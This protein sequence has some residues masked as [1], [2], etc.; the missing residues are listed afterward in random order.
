MAVSAST[1]AQ[2][3]AWTSARS[4][5]APSTFRSC[6][7]SRLQRFPPQRPD[8]KIGPSTARGFVAP[9]SRSWS[10][11]RFRSPVGLAAFRHLVRR[12]FSRSSPV[13]RTLRSFPLSSSRP[14]RHRFPL[15]RGRVPRS[16]PG[17]PSRRHR[18]APPPCRHDCGHPIRPQGV[19]PLKSPFAP[20]RCCHPAELDA[21]M[22]FGSNT[23][24]VCR[25]SLLRARA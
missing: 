12:C 8:P 20:A 18:I 23:F 19:H 4:C 6:R 1:P 10:S 9:R 16:P 13:A 22:G 15:P 24:R 25:G 3:V 17:V 11:P 2:A 7:S 14:V 21:P 5:H